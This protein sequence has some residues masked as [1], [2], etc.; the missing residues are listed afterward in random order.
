[1]TGPVFFSFSGDY[2]VTY[3][4]HGIDD[5]ELIHP[6]KQVE[7][8]G[9]AAAAGM[10]GK[11]LLSDKGGQIRKTS[12]EITQVSDQISTDKLKILYKNSY[13]LADLLFQKEVKRLSK[14]DS[15]CI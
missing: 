7:N 9:F 2:T 6:E 14:I 4:I 11:E 3:Y 5:I 15:K 12:E 10:I 13:K 8:V 1:M